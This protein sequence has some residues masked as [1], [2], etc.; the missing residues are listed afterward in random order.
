[1]IFWSGVTQKMSYKFG[2]YAPIEHPTATFADWLAIGE[3]E[4]PLREAHRRLGNR[5]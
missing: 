3:S 5:L 1:M 2:D 4:N